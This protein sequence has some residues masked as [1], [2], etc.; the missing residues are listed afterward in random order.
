M[1]NAQNLQRK[2][3]EVTDKNENVLKTI[4]DSI[5]WNNG[6]LNFSIHTQ[7][8]NIEWIATFL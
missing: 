2:F 5:E 4:N 6:V 1:V 7:N 8:E 3:S